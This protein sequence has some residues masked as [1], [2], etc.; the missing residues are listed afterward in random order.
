MAPAKSDKRVIERA[1]FV[2]DPVSS[3]KLTE[4]RKPES[5]E[6][7]YQEI[8]LLEPALGALARELYRCDSTIDDR[9]IN[10]ILDHFFREGIK[11]PF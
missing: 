11:A 2:G 4:W 1:R 7:L 5:R 3:K 9:T 10:V 8:A 6:K